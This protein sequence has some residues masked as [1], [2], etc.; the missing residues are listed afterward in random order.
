[1]PNRN[2]WTIIDPNNKE[3]DISGGT[4]RARE[5]AKK[6][7][8]ACSAI[9]DRMQQLE[10]LDIAAR[11]GQSILGRLIG[12]NYAIFSKQRARLAD[13]F[14]KSMAAEDGARV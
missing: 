4:A 1:L 11:K 5:I 13:I 12:G 10:R 7:R 9:K 3:N 6:F 8:D 2:K 14:V